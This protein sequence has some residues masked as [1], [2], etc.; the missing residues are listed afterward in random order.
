MPKPKSILIY[1]VETTGL[2]LHPSVDISK[3]P[4]IIEFGGVLLDGAFNTIEEEFSIL[5]NPGEL[6][7][8]E[9][10]KI[11]GITNEDLADQPDFKTLLPTFRRIF[12]A[13][14][15]VVAHNL[16]FDKTVLLGELKRHNITDFPW[17]QCELCTVAMY[18]DD[19]GRDPKLIELYAHIMGKPFEQKH[20]AL[21]DVHAL[22]EIFHQERL[23][24]LAE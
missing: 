8:E 2:T 6:I 17:P 14:S 15:T 18:R 11:T 7:T 4:K 5:V 24:D 19:W 3:Q 22:A 21:S 1:D 13:A 23:M 12:S 20:R 10:T 9:I 16:P